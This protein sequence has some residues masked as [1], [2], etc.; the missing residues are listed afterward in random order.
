MKNEKNILYEDLI[1]AVKRMYKILPVEEENVE[2]EKRINNRMQEI[3]NT[4]FPEKNN[5]NREH[6]DVPYFAMLLFNIKY[7]VCKKF[8]KDLTSDIITTEEQ[9]YIQN[10]IIPQLEEEFHKKDELIKIRVIR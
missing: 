2:I 10:S 5:F 3:E 1:Y 9:E 7:G 6:N 8:Q 4:S